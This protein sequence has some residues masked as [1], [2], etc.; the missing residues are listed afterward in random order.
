MFPVSIDGGSL[1]ERVVQFF[2]EV[3]ELAVFVREAGARSGRALLLGSLMLLILLAS[4][5]LG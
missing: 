5:S 1:M 2:D 4:T 3:D